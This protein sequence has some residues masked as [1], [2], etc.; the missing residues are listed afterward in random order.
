MESQGLAG[1][2][3]V[4]DRTYRRLRDRFRFE[5]RGPIEV[6]GKGEVVTWFLLASDD[7][8]RATD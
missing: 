5:R 2:I 3:Q 4:T 6:K 8:D 7:G 1:H